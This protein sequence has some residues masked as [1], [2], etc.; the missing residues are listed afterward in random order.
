MDLPTQTHLTT[1][2]ELLNFRRGELRAD[3]RADQLA[4]HG[5][6]EAAAHEVLDHK[7]KQRSNNW[8]T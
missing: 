4:G 6:A 5:S 1:L 2:R 7:V 8:P 3:V